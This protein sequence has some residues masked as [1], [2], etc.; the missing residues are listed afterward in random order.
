MRMIILLQ[1]PDNVTNRQDIANILATL[2]R[3]LAGGIYL[4]YFRLHVR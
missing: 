1:H 3:P 4:S 2:T